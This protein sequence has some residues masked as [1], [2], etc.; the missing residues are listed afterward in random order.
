MYSYPPARMGGDVDDYHRVDIAAGHGAG[1]PTA[2][3]IAADTYVL[4]FLDA[5]LGPA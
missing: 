2:K 4:A 3:A 1:K 5:V